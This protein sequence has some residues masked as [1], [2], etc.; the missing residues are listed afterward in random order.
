MARYEMQIDGGGGTESKSGSDSKQAARQLMPQTF[1]AIDA[2]KEKSA[3]ASKT[4]SES[5]ARIQAAREGIAAA[6]A[7]IET[8]RK[9]VLAIQERLRTAPP[10]PNPVVV[11][12]EEDRR[13]VIVD[14]D[15]NPVFVNPTPPTPTPTN[16]R[17]VV[18]SPPPPPTKTAPLDTILYNEEDQPVE[19][20][21]DLIFENIGGQELINIA[22]TDTVNG[23]P[24][25]Y[26][27]IKNLTQIQQQFN[28][29]NIV[30][31]QATSDKYFQNFAIKLENKVP[32]EGNGPAGAHV[33][34]DPQ[35]GDLVVEAINL[36]ADEQIELEIT[37]SGT[38]YEAEL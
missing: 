37:T 26:Q 29:N 17:P 3:S 21:T 34:I 1:A 11:T 35:T 16:S 25:V 22:R 14:N 9:N 12:N 28:P 18:V 27:P 36:E 2:A 10:S 23:Q 7:K 8:A 32:E 15:R 31:L 6:Q 24:I 4:I 13:R 19:I 20:M 38:I 5:R 30:A 33:Y